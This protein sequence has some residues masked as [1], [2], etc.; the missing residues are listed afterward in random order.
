MEQL[1][2]LL[3][4]FGKA[5]NAGHQDAADGELNPVK[6]FAKYIPV[7]LAVQPAF[8]GI[9]QIGAELGKATV[10]AK[11]AALA[12]LSG[13]LSALSEADAYDLST[14][15]AGVVNGISYVKRKAYEKGRADLAAEIRAGSVSVNDL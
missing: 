3:Q 4:F 12:A 2:E 9:D 6:D 1:N 11:Q 13:E 14:F 7:L 10:E 5:V 15:A 8:Q